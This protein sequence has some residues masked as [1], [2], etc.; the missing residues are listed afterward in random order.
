MGEVMQERMGRGDVVGNLGVTSLVTNAYV[1]TGDDKYRRWVIDYV[2]A[3]QRPRAANGGL[4]PDNV[5]LSGEVGEYIDGKW[6]GGLYGWTWPHGF[7]NIDAAAIVAGSCALLLTG[8]RSL[9][10]RTPG[11]VAA[12][13]GTGA[14]T[15]CAH[16]PMSLGHHWFG[17]VPR[18]GE[19]ARIVR[20]AISVWRSWMVRLPAADADLSGGA[21]ESCRR[22]D[23]DWHCIEELR[24]Q[25]SVR[26]A[27]GSSI[28]QQRR[29]RP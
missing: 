2:E 10:G 27:A 19:P 3:W 15:R 23:D 8:E 5:G 12:C 11:P 21:L 25:K 17:Q 1:M 24:Q 6:Y 16:A 14:D 20:R 28:P 4:L 7:Y 13:S 29:V 9:S 18:D 26:L 22:R